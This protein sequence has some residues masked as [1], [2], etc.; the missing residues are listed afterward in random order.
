M[1]SLLARWAVK[2]GCKPNSRKLESVNGALLGRENFLGSDL[3]GLSIFGLAVNK[4]EMICVC[5]REVGISRWGVFAG[6]LEGNTTRA[7]FKGGCSEDSVGR[8]FRLETRLALSLNS[9]A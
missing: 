4:E 1:P 6:G 2:S 5:G 8:F 3:T 7:R 9:K